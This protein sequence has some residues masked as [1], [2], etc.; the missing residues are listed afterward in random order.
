MDSD[1]LVGNWDAL[2]GNW[3]ALVRDWDAPTLCLGILGNPTKSE[4]IRG[5]ARFPRLLGF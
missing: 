1:A 5:T 2:V 3:D 4:E